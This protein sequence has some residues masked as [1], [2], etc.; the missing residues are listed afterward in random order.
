MK[1]T[2]NPLDSDSDDEKLIGDPTA[3][4][5]IELLEAKLRFVN[6]APH[7]FCL[8]LNVFRLIEAK[9]EREKLK[10]DAKRRKT[11]PM[12]EDP[13]PVVCSRNHLIAVVEASGQQSPSSELAAAFAFLLLRHSELRDQIALAQQGKL[14]ISKARI[15]LFHFF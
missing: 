12:A 3:E 5:S 7:Q 15:A 4:T 13:D 14:T 11:I 2:T 8:F 6:N 1:R 10:R 9:Y